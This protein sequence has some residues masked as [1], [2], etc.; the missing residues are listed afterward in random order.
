MGNR[1]RLAIIDLG[2]NSIRFDVHEFRLKEGTKHHF[3][4]VCIHRDKRMIR[5]GQDLYLRGTLHPEAK[6]RATLALK[7]FAE[8]A[9]RFGVSQI[10][11]FATSALR[12]ARDRN[13]FLRQVR[14]ELGIQLKIL[15]G[16]QEAKLIAL[17]ILKNEPKLPKNFVI[18][19]IGGGSSEIIWCKGREILDY[20]SFKLGSTRLHQ[21]YFQAI[22]PSR[23]AV[24]QLRQDIAKAL[25]RALQSSLQ[26]SL[27]PSEKTPLLVGSSGTGRVI[28]AIA[29]L[30]RG[31]EKK[32]KKSAL[33][34][35]S[36]Q[37]LKAYSK[38]I[39]KM[40]LPEL[41][42]IPT[43]TAQRADL[44]PAGVLLLEEIAK[45][46]HAK[47]IRSTDYSLRDGLLSQ[48]LER[49]SRPD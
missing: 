31:Q 4:S 40:T 47:K 15:S 36:V 46:I 22:P 7:V 33:R 37:D 17:G 1:R 42:T 10:N 32:L 28:S 23:E 29:A 38:R 16:K 27:Q 2:T 26:S 21:V 25:H 34:S 39:C 5:L 12:D 30:A 14:S 44:L 18:V 49:P 9:R 45:A 35:I 11:A 8:K 20:N 6:A 43:V 19:D 48:E 41:L 24:S 3:T 13:A